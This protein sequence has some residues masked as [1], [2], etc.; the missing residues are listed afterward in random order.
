M[1]T[2]TVRAADD[3]V[4]GNPLREKARGTVLEVFDTFE[5]FDFIFIFFCKINHSKYNYSKR[6]KTKS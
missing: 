6:K 4:D 2:I 3:E 5:T 1:D